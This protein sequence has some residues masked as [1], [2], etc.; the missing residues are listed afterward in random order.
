M[1]TIFTKILQGELP[2]RFVARTPTV[3]A[4]LS[5]APLTA[6]HT[7]VVPVDEVDDWTQLS[8]ERAGE[9]M[10]MAHLI[11]GAVKQAFAS[12]RAA[13]IIAGF[14]VPH[15]HLHVFPVWEMAD[16]D[17][18]RAEPASDDDLAAAQQRIL[19]VLPPAG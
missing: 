3:A 6:G 9:L 16:L 19:D 18:A 1:T 2:G 15:T 11:G 14:E 13:L 12:P 10:G 5:I 17:F 8:P 4:F 7:L